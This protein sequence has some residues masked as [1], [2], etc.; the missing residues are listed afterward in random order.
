MKIKR[1]GLVLVC[2]FSPNLVHGLPDFFI[3]GP[4]GLRTLVLLEPCYSRTSLVVQMVKNLP[5]MQETT[6]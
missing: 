2:L 6:G 1:Q 4:L 5:V 3:S